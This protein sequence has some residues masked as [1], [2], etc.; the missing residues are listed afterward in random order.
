MCINRRRRNGIEAYQHRNSRRGRHERVSVRCTTSFRANVPLGPSSP[1][2]GATSTKQHRNGA[3]SSGAPSRA[4][5]NARKKYLRQRRRG[6]IYNFLLFFF[7][8]SHYIEIAAS[9]GAGMTRRQSGA[10]AKRLL[11]RNE[12]TERNELNTALRKKAC[13]FYQY[14]VRKSIQLRVRA[15]KEQLRRN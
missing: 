5:T 11:F 13:H 10:A 15:R 14:V 7:L 9:L 8:C 6:I 2:S 4:A 3:I 1:H 12:W